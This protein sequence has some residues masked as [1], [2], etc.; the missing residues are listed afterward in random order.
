[1]RI[2]SDGL[3][4]DKLTFFSEEFDRKLKPCSVYIFAN[5]DKE[6]DATGV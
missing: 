5:F 3:Y 2:V 4:Y 1:M 6:M